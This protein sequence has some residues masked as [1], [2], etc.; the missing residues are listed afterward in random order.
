MA[1]MNKITLLPDGKTV[2]VEHG[3]KRSLLEI[4]KSEGTY[5]KSSCG[6]YASCSDCIIKIRS[7]EENITPPTFP[8][9]NLLGNVFHITKER[10]SCQI[11]L[12]GGDI[13]VD[14][15]EHDKMSDQEQ[16]KNKT[17]SLHAKNVLRRTAEEKEKVIQERKEISAQKN[18]GKFNSDGKREKDSGFNRPK[19]P[20]KKS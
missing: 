11:E 7:G 12:V 18:E 10:L 3:D 16:I 5:V 2:E 6:G 15:S 20:F 17:S 13:S 1:N 14:I 8:E 4:L 19:D 9:I